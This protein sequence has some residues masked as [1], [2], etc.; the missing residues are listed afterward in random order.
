MPVLSQAESAKSPYK[1]ALTASPTG[2]EKPFKRDEDSG[3]VQQAGH[4]AL[5]RRIGVR[6]PAPESLQRCIAAQNVRAKTSP[7]KLFGSSGLIVLRRWPF[8]MLA[9]SSRGQ[10]RCPLTAE[11]RVRIS[12]GPFVTPITSAHLAHPKF[13]SIVLKRPAHR[14]DLSDHQAS[15][16]LCP[17]E[18]AL[19]YTISEARL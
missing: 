6:I 5:D 17:C 13:S 9:P 8:G 12:V 3:V 19:L 11:T 10:G 2:C 7:S 16:P 18:H 1:V 14:S 4:A 15:A